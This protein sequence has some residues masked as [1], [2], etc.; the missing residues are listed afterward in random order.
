MF[1]DELMTVIHKVETIVLNQKKLRN[2]EH[3][4]KQY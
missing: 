2:L 3:Q 4:N 1:C